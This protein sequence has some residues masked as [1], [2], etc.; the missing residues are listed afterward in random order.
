MKRTRD[1]VWN[2][3][4]RIF[5]EFELE[6]QREEAAAKTTQANP[7]ARPDQAAAPQGRQ[8]GQAQPKR[9]PGDQPMN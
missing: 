9:K 8:P 3:I 2:E 5:V 1:E 4:A 6:M 7:H